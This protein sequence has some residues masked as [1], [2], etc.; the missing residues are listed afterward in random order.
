MSRIEIESMQPRGV[1]Q[2]PKPPLTCLIC[3]GSRHRVVFK[4]FGTDL[5]Q[6]R[7][8]GHVFSSHPA[9]PHYD[10]FWG[11]EVADADPYWSTARQPMYQEFLERFAAGGFGRLLDMGCGLGF[12]VK[13][14]SQHREWQAYGCE[15]SPAAV[16]YG[17]ERLGLANVVCSRLESVDLPDRSFD[18][19]TMWDVI[20][21]VLQPDPLI[22]R[23]YSLLKDGGFCFIRTPNVRVQLARARVN[24]VIRGMKTGV[25]YLQARDHA[26][27]Y[28]M[29]SIR[30]L[31]QRNGFADVEFV[32]L[33]PVQAATGA[34]R[35]RRQAKVAGFHA[36]R[37]LAGLTG[38]RLN[39]DN[40]FVI[41]RKT[42]NQTGRPS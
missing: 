37:A 7:A 8:C 35:L 15:I 30:Q 34:S 25:T 32:H 12:F 22:R 9:D 33:R 29:S 17:R 5:L 26:H 11:S 31:L 23:G 38:G 6:C 18:I 16:R 13:A 42:P 3:G 36:V 10:G 27:H 28:S 19:I 41:A 20:D 21:H 1:L 14:V 24:R 4:E 40:L 39:L 2:S